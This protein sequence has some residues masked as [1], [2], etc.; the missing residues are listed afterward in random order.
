MFLVTFFFLRNR[1]R[2]IETTKIMA[3]IIRV[4][5]SICIPEREKFSIPQI[6]AQAMI[7]TSAPGII[8]ISVA[9]AKGSHGRRRNPER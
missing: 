7:N 4:P 6:E 3:D 5:V 9:S 2:S 8:P 1:A